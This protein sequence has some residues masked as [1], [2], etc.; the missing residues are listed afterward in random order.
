MKDAY[1]KALSNFSKPATAEKKIYDHKFRFTLL[2]PGD[3]MYWES[4]IYKVLE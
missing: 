1:A 4:Q 2:K 3:R